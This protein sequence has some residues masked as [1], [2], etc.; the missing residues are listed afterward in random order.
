[1]NSNF[2]RFKTL[3]LRTMAGGALEVDVNDAT[4]NFKRTCM[5]FCMFL[6]LY[7]GNE[8]CVEHQDCRN[9]N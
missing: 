1:M 7:D 2:R 4:S 9:R 5:T 3:A 6:N 8:Q